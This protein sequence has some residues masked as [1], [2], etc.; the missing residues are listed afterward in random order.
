[1]AR[2]KELV[3]Y[4][5]GITLLDHTATN[6]PGSTRHPHHPQ[7]AELIFEKFETPSLFFSR[8]A[9]LSCYSVSTQGPY[10]MRLTPF[11][12]QSTAPTTRVEC[13]QGQYRRPCSCLRQRS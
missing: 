9:V 12:F 1:M 4:G 7:H 5:D 10:A 11:T 8:D 3:S 2:L 13:H 6:D